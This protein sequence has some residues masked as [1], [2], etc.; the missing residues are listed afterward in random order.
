MTGQTIG[1]VDDD[2][3][4]RAGVVYDGYN[5]ASIQMHVAAEGKHWLNREFL[6]YAFHYP[7]EQLKVRAVIGVVPS[8]NAKALRFDLHLGFKEEARLRDTHPDGDL[9][10]LVMRRADCRFLERKVHESRKIVATA[11]A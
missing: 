10:I 9:I 2:Y 4:L 1:L 11:S 7:F 5:G 6:W 3:R 8:N